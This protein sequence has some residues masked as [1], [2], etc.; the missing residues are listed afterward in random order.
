MLVFFAFLYSKALTF[1]ATGVTDLSELDPEEPPEYFI[2]Q[3]ARNSAPT[4]AIQWGGWS[5]FLFETTQSI[6][7]R[8]IYGDA[9]VAEV[10]GGPGPV[11]LADAF[12]IAQFVCYANWG[13]E[14]FDGYYSQP[15]YTMRTTDG[16]IT[17]IAPIAPSASVASPH[18][19]RDSSVSPAVE[20]VTGEDD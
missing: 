16:C 4:P 2:Q 12:P 20:P 18:A 7:S 11:Q 14:S 17:P 3:L 1:T 9:G 5:T 13:A 6:D 8:F 19:S 15:A 10:I